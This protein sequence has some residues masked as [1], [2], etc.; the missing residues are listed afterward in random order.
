[1]AQLNELKKIKRL[2]GEK[3]SRLCR[4]LFPQILENEGQLLKILLEIFSKNCNTLYES[5]DENNLVEDFKN[6]IYSVFD[7]EKEN[8][9]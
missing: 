4:E 1:M 3:F 8:K 7:N 9:K 5:I 2:Y 6:L